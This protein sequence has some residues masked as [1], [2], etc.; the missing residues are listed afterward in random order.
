M[1]CETLCRLWYCPHV[2]NLIAAMPTVVSA[3]CPEKIEIFKNSVYETQPNGHF[4]RKLSNIVSPADRMSA[5][6]TSF[7]EGF[8]EAQHP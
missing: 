1:T 6:E 4:L 5:R 3:S 8:P 2:C 7:I